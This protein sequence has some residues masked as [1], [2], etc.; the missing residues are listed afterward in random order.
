MGSIALNL[1][2]SGWMSSMGAPVALETGRERSAFGSVQRS[3]FDTTAEAR[4]G[5]RRSS[6]PP[7][8][9][10]GTKGC[11]PLGRARREGAA[12]PMTRRRDATIARAV[13]SHA[14]SKCTSR[15]PPR[16]G[17][18]PVALAGRLP[19]ASASRSPRTLKIFRRAQRQSES[20]GIRTVE[21]NKTL[22]RLA[23]DHRDGGLLAAES[24][25]L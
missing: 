7:T 19:G 14:H 25:D 11:P 24:L 4:P 13:T 20:G 3:R 5:R 12:C 2:V 6:H 18:S 9:R 15:T 22:A 21:A 1:R 17:R 8:H 10:K 16:R 23:V